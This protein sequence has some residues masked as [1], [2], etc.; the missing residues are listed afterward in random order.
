[1]CARVCVCAHAR[2]RE[3]TGNKSGNLKCMDMKKYKVFK[4]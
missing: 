2:Q 4:N 3:A 1:M